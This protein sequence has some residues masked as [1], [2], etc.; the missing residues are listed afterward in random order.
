MAKQ[1]WNRITEVRARG[2]EP[3]GLNYSYPCGHSH[4]MSSEDISAYLATG[5]KNA[6]T[7]CPEGCE[8]KEVTE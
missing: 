1:T 5:E 3:A 4:F 6:P 8:V 2:G 7:E